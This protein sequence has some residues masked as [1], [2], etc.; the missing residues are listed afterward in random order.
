MKKRSI[1][2]SGHST[3]ITLEEEFW[4]ALQEIVIEQK[5]SMN[6]LI[7]EIDQR[8]E[9]DNLSS[10]IRLYILKRYQEKLDAIIL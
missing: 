2:I 5:T 7:S 3:S 1:K 9:N 6:A 4:V 8:R 10:A